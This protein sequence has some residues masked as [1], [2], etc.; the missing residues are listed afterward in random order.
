[1]GYERNVVVLTRE[2]GYE[3]KPQNARMAELR[4]RRYPRFVETLKNRHRVYNETLKEIHEMEKTGDTFVIRPSEKLTISRMEKDL[5]EI[6]RV[7]DIGRKDAENHIDALCR[8]MEA[9]AGED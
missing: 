4:Y 9:S 3:K 5:K 8:W 6:Q 1:M 7:Y 2:D